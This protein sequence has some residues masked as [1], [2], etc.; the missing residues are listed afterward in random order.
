[1]SPKIWIVGTLQQ[2]SP[3]PGSDLCC[4][5]LPLLGSGEVYL[6]WKR[7]LR[8]LIELHRSV[9]DKPVKMDM[10][11]TDCFFQNLWLNFSVYF[12]WDL[13]SLIGLIFMLFFFFFSLYNTTKKKLWDGIQ[14][15][16][17]CYL[18]HARIRKLSDSSLQHD[19]EAYFSVYLD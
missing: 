9:P 3:T 10:G 17:G 15:V 11:T 5:A 14:F 12:I 13:I 6:V 4:S 1:M 2:C 19:S 7:L 16:Y 8:M 18:S